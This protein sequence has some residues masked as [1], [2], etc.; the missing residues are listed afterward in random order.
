MENWRLPVDQVDCG[1]CD[2]GGHSHD[3]VI[4]A[5]F[6][7]PVV[8]VVI[9]VIALVALAATGL[10]LIFDIKRP[11][12]FFYLLTKPNFRSWLVI[13][14]YILM[15]YGAL[16]VAWLLC[17][18]MYGGVPAALAVVT[19]VL[20]AAS[21]C[22]SAFLFAQARGRDLWQSSMFFW[23]LL[24]QAFVAG[25]AAFLLASIYRVAFSPVASRLESTINLY[26]TGRTF[27]MLLFFLGVSLA[28]V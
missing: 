24:V 26:M 10:L 17:G 23:H 13:G 18:T 8:N 15:A 14:A 9:P 25:A 20:G 6:G 16:C 1:R 4:R 2:A 22:Y 3:G 11:D 12:R 28:M 21:A 5:F 19:A 27:L 7:G